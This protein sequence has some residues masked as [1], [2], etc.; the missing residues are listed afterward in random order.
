MIEYK[1]KKDGKIIR[2]MYFDGTRKCADEIKDAVFARKGMSVGV[3]SDVVGVTRLIIAGFVIGAG[4]YVVIDLNSSV[5]TLEYDTI[6][7]NYEPIYHAEPVV[8]AAQEDVA[9]SPDY[10]G[11][12]EYV[13]KPPKILAMQY[14]GTLDCAIKIRDNVLA[15]INGYGCFSIEVGVERV[16][17]KYCDKHISKDD[18]VVITADYSDSQVDVVYNRIFQAKYGTA[19]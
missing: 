3:H 15:V 13:K 2:A 7:E 1:R 9:G 12:K 5:C 17:F 6:A 8:D 14:D 4:S 19:S 18:F 11:M 10:T 16:T